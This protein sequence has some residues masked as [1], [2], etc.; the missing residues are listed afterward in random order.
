MALKTVLRNN[1]WVALQVYLRYGRAQ[2]DTQLEAVFGTSD[3]NSGKTLSLTDFLAHLHANQA[4]NVL[5][6]SPDLCKD[7]LRASTTGTSRLSLRAWVIVYNILMGLYRDAPLL[8]QCTQ[9]CVYRLL[10]CGQG[11]RQRL[12]SRHRCPAAKG[13]EQQA[14][15]ELSVRQPLRI[16]A[17]KSITHSSLEPR[18]WQGLRQSARRDSHRR[19]ADHGLGPGLEH[20]LAPHS[21]NH[22][23]AVNTS[24]LGGQLR[25]LPAASVLCLGQV[26]TVFRP[27]SSP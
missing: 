13:R 16:C 9:L 5:E 8:S 22:L 20:K 10:S 6:E 11:S 2:L 24:S 15:H 4:R 25:R 12:T 14:E 3:L 26:R 27:P 23:Q 18:R 7:W 21:R 1:G 19:L 17:T